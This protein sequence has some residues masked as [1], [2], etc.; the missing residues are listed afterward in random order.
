MAGRPSTNP[1][2]SLQLPTVVMPELAP[3]GKHMLGIWLRY[4][5]GE[6]SE[7]SWNDLR[8]P[9]TENL[10]R[11]LE[12]YAPGFRDLVEWC[13]LYTPED[14]ESQTGITG[15]S[16]RHLDMTIDQ[17][18]HRRPLPS[19]SAYQSPIPNLWLCGSGTHPCGSVTGAPGHNAAHALLNA[20]AK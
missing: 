9:V 1:V 20:D 5:P 7:G 16:I 6:L 10:F 13:R 2:M 3:P 12:E 15:A 14:I 4:G 8:E 11:I 17:M 18:L 19:W